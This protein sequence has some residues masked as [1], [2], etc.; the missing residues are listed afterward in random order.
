MRATASTAQVTLTDPARDVNFS[1]DQSGT[2]LQWL[3]ENIALNA[4]ASPGAS[5]LKLSWGDLEDI[6]AIQRER[7][8]GFD[9]VL[10]SDII[11]DPDQ[12]PVLLQ[13]MRT[14]CFATG[15]PC[16]LGY[17]VRHPGEKQL[18]AA[19]NEDFDVK[20]TTLGPH[21]DARASDAAIVAAEF[22]PRPETK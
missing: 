18:F 21:G 1:D 10:G 15:A 2:T 19:A 8:E 22:W 3:L 5:A 9:L 17:Q 4:D 20:F 13:T 11:Y 16:V 14:F 6:R 7:L 12:Y